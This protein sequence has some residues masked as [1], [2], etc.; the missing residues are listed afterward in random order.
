[1]LT[2]CATD[3]FVEA[4]GSADGGDAG[5]TVSCGASACAPG[6]TCCIYSGSGGTQYACNAQ[7]G[8]AEGGAQLSV[9]A[10]TSG[11]DCAGE[12]CCIRQSN[13]GNVS[14]CEP[15][16]NTT[17]GEVQLC[18]PNAADAGCSASQPCSTDNIGDW[19]LPNGFATCGG[20]SVP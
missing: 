18:D 19:G 13:G 14:I 9:L 15:Q 11:A 7:C 10:C 4:D 5:P 3:T 17:N 6:E 8:Q 2:A 20:R 1:M 16:C 12:A